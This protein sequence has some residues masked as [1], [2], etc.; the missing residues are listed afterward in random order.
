MLAPAKRTTRQRQLSSQQASNLLQRPELY[1]NDNA[2]DR[3]ERH[4]PQP[5]QTS[6][7]C[8]RPQFC[9]AANGT[10]SRALGNGFWTQVGPV[11]YPELLKLET[12]SSGE[13]EAHVRVVVG[14]EHLNLHGT[15]HGGFLY[16]LADEA[17]ALASKSR[18]TGAVVLNAHIDYFSVV[19]EG[20]VLEATAREEHLGRRVATYRVDITRQGETVALFSGTVYRMNSRS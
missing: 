6:G 14:P 18:G 4:V 9:G 11:K 12:L 10:A 16:S 2:Q 20:E 19:R 8:V 15:A 13:G 5:G 3:S 17:L 1:F 7:W